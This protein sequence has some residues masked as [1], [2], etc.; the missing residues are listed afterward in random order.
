M[1]AIVDRRAPD[2]RSD[3][4]L[5]AVAR[6]ALAALHGASGL[7]ISPLRA[8]L[9]RAIETLDGVHREI[10]ERCDLARR[11]H[12]RVVSELALS[13]RQFYRDRRTALIA[14]ARALDN[15]RPIV[16][17]SPSLRD[18][19]E[20]LLDRLRGAGAYEL[21]AR[22]ASELA[23]EAS[24]D[25]LIE[26]RLWGVASEASR[27]LGRVREAEELLDRAEGASVELG[28]GDDAFAKRLWIAV[29]RIA[30]AAREA[31]Y[32]QARAIF[33]RTQAYV[34]DERLLHGRGAILFGILLSFAGV[35]E[36]DCGDWAA[37]SDLLRRA[38]RL[39]GRAGIEV[40]R[41][42]LLRLSGVLA[43]RSSGDVGR[44][45]EDL[46]EALALSARLGQHGAQA[47]AAVHLGIALAQ[48]SRDDAI[49]HLDFGLE[50]AKRFY[51]GDGFA[52]MVVEALPATLRL[53]GAARAKHWLR[54]AR[55]T[56]NPG[57]RDALLLDLGE[58]QLALV[59]GEAEAGERADAAAERLV[60][61]GVRAWPWQRGDRPC[62]SAAG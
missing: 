60:R 45:I 49:A 23:A 5:L 56:A 54:A 30:L 55:D 52:K 50:L 10:V 6:R 3:D 35:V 27:Y 24:G 16:G 41:P 57:R 12:K 7:A 58:A 8:R 29:G 28:S 44:A 47:H 46:R 53:H 9:L 1:D 25:G 4:E 48:S 42:G 22:D 33:E 40:S 19:R 13:R 39:A 34:A 32:A 14:L 20:A 38:Q 15:E 43:L 21:V 31:E 17:V 61:L 2:R 18:V 51:P 37:A 11:P 62:R 26:I 59:G 36:T